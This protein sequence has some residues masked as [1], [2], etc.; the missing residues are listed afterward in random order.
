L[1]PRQRAPIR[2]ECK[3]LSSSGPPRPLPN[4]AEDRAKSRAPGLIK[5]QR[6]DQQ[7]PLG[8]SFN[9]VVLAP[10][11]TQPAKCGWR[12]VSG[13]WR[14]HSRFTIRRQGSHRTQRREGAQTGSGRASPAPDA[15]YLFVL[16]SDTMLNTSTLRSAT[17]SLITGRKSL[18]CR[19][20][21][22][23]LIAASSL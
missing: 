22:C 18:K 1:H 12:M 11:W 23:V 14:A 6:G 16:P 5:G 21:W 2:I 3:A 7:V 13:Q 8:R 4:V 15:R 9:G 19:L 20:S 17:S 10:Q